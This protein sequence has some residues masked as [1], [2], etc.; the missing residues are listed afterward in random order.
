MKKNQKKIIN[1]KKNIKIIN[2]ALGLGQKKKNL[3]ITNLDRNLGKKTKR[4]KTKGIKKTK[5]IKIPKIG[6]D[7]LQAQKTK[8]LKIKEKNENIRQS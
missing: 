5:K 1:I 8:N 3:K 6:K 4:V 7:L 2:L